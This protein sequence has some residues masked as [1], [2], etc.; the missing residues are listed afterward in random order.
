MKLSSIRIVVS[1]AIFLVG[2]ALGV[3]GVQAAEESIK[4][5]SLP[6]SVAIAIKNRFP[7]GEIIAAAKET[8]N[9]QVM[10]DIELKQKNRKFESDI[11]ED[12]TIVE[13][14][15]EVAAKDWPKALSDSVAAKYPK[16]KIQEVMEVNKVSGKE[17]TPEYF[18]VTI[19]TLDNKNTEIIA[20]LDGKQLSVENDAALA[21]EKENR[22]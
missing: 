15:K 5:E 18:E 14:E 16:S 9:G 20:S 19:K 17:E 6:K 7:G 13:I 8:E 10:F 11:K 12:G 4:P 22:G 3:T 21:A 2:I 1:A